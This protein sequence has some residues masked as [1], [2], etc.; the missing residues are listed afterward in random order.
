ME[1]CEAFPSPFFSVVLLSLKELLHLCGLCIFSVAF[2]SE[3]FLA[4]Q[5]WGTFLCALQE[6]A[7]FINC[8]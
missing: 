6:F 3:L 7:A 5:Y 1:S 4:K 2:P 8:Y